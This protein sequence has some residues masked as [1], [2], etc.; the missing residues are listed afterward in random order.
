[1]DF[2]SRQDEA[3]KRTKWLIIYFALAV[4]FITLAI[5]LVIAL[6]FLRPPI[7]RLGSDWRWLWN[8]LAISATAT[9]TLGF[10]LIASFYKMYAVGHSGSVVAVL[11][12]GSRLN[13]QTD[14]PDERRLLNV[15]EEMSI[16]SGTPVPDL[17]VL[18]EEDGINA[19]AAGASVSDAAIGVTRGAM[20]L[21]SRD[22]MQGVIAHEF[23]HILNGDMK[24]NTRLIG[25][26]HGILCIALLGKGLLYAMSGSRHR[27][28]RGSTDGRAALIF[29]VLGLAL[30]LIGSIGSF[31]GRLI[32]SAVSRQREY[33]ADA[34]AVQFTRNP[35]GLAGALKKIGGLSR[36]SRLLTSHAEEASHMFFGNALSRSWVQHMATHPP[37]EERI[38]LL[39]PYFDGTFPKLDAPPPIPVSSTDT[40]SSS[41]RPP[42]YV[43]PPQMA[44]L[45]GAP[46]A[47]QAEFNAS[48]ML[49][50][51]GAPQA[52]HLDFA[53]QLLASLPVLLAE[54]VHE[55]LRATAVV[56]ALLLSPEPSAR[57]AQLTAL[58]S[59]APAAVWNE[60][61]RCKDAV[62]HL[63]TQ[64]RLPLVELALP[65]LRQLSPAQYDE[66]RAL[67]RHIIESDRQIDLFEYALQKMLLRHLGPSFEQPVRAPIQY[68]ALNGLAGECRVLLSGLAHLGHED[69]DQTARAFALG[70]QTLRF[71]SSGFTL[72][73]QSN[74]NLPDID[75][76]L[77]KLAQTTA[78]LKKQ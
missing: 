4:L 74:S 48:Q 20:K 12:G 25:I 21:L 70:R 32:K 73:P 1:M 51:I 69:P 3:R 39:D 5:Y 62:T 63:E 8:P 9:G 28:S 52:G 53:V 36:G 15:V 26:V 40:A 43:S 57:E 46:L 71:D 59:S 60:V 45:V 10:I 30:L 29:L 22:E 76:A 44:D 2:F 14:D 64:A 47:G 7:D 58:E 55:P 72:L 23:S 41:P 19:F 50:S 37:L 16:A 6:I 11:M 66:F 18:R 35:Q 31:F 49:D 68:Y 77:D 27:R 78:P 34:A 56:Y 75:A 42:A 24:L 67:V 17:F 54:A 33:L 13:P 61:K 38:R 65:A